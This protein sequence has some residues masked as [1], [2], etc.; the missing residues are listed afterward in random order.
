MAGVDWSRTRAYAFGLSG[1]YI[2][3]AGR[4]S[5]GIV[6]A[7]EAASL[8]QEIVEK[9]TGLHDSERDR[10]AIRTVYDGHIKYHGPYVSN[11]PD[12]IV[13]YEKGYRA[14]W[15]NAVGKIDGPLFHD[16]DRFWSGDHCVDP[17]LVPGVLFVNRKLPAGSQPSIMDLAP[18]ILQLFGVPLPGYL[19]GKPLTLTRS[20]VAS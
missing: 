4:E 6:P 3:Q 15:E 16:N 5:Q 7:A 11:G 8:R 12:L 17:E 19:D 13:G 18:T 14:S 10:C 1:I 2:N 9:L 20:E